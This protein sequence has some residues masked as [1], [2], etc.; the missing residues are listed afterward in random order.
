MKSE[1]TNYSIKLRI[2]QSVTS[3]FWIAMRK[4]YIPLLFLSGTAFA[5]EVLLDRICAT[6]DS[7]IILQSEIQERLDHGPLEVRVSDYGPTEAKDDFTRALND[8]INA[9]LIFRDAEQH[10]IVI[11]DEQINEEIEHIKASN[12]LSQEGLERQLARDHKTLAQFKKDLRESRIF[13][14]WA[15]MRIM[16]LNKTTDRDVEAYYLTKEGSSSESQQLLLKKIDVPIDSQ[17]QV[18][19]KEKLASEI[20]E[21]LKSGLS[22]DAAQ[23]LYTAA[24]ADH[25]A[26]PYETSDFGPTIRPHLKDLKIGEYSKPIRLPDRFVIF[27][28][29]DKHLVASQDFIRRKPQL[30][31]ELRDL[32]MKRLTNQW[33]KNERSRSNIVII[34]E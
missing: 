29:S 1:W 11:K 23:T 24:D 3:N 13:N 27:F 16:P 31:K 15:G 28:V 22:F 18:E 8:T 14:R 21:K 2:S 25:S 20:Y 4:L 17:V 9:R 10:E 32:E 33:L 5:E 7:E 12:H 6:V 34:K 19:E 26:K 30:Q